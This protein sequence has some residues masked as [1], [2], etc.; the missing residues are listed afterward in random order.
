MVINESC[1]WTRARG[2]FSIGK[3]W[4]ETL[5]PRRAGRYG[6]VA[7]MYLAGG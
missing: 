7:R 5:T 1:R 6:Q 2:A 3:P 4:A